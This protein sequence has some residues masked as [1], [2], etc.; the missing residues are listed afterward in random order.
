L[1]IVA[2]GLGVGARA[3]SRQASANK[4]HGNYNA[5]EILQK[6][7]PICQAVA[8]A[9]VDLRLTAT[10]LTGRW[11]NGIWCVW[12]IYGEERGNRLRV[13]VLMDAF[14]A[15]PMLISDTSR[16]KP[17]TSA[18]RLARSEALFSARQWM[19]QLQIA[20]GKSRW[21]LTHESSRRQDG[22]AFI[23]RSMDRRARIIVNKETG[24][25]LSAEVLRPHVLEIES[26]LSGA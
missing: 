21:K 1:L 16:S 10:P 9:G 25:L 23:W 6:A 8:P 13:Y 15:Q 24:A 18:R 22:W 7:T 5:R 12:A 26:T 20:R 11:R 14:S 2:V 19:K 17:Q 3:W 4:L